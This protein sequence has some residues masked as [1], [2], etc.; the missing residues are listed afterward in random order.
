ML[1]DKSE[2]NIKQFAQLILTKEL[3]FSSGSYSKLSIR[4]V[5]KCLL[6]NRRRY[7]ACR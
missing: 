1:L 3:E 2:I 6:D 7:E 5:S 4:V